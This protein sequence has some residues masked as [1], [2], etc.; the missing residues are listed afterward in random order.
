[1]RANNFTVHD[2]IYIVTGGHELDLHN[3][4]AFRSLKY[5]IPTQ[6]LQLSWIR[7]EADWNRKD[8]PRKLILTFE[9]V[10]SLEL[11][12]REPAT[13]F[14]EDDCLANIGHLSN[15]IGVEGVF[16]CDK[17][18]DDEWKWVFEF[19]SGMQIIVQAKTVE[20]NTEPD[21]DRDSPR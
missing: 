3:W 1:M 19:M 10:I 9:Q 11:H 18:P 14:S 20:A 7:T 5:D 16:T 15:A 12:P 2:S 4:Y 8:V 21:Q 13:P 17:I 6:V